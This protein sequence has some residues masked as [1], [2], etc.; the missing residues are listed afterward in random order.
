MGNKI[1]NYMGPLR[2]NVLT[3][4]EGFKGKCGCR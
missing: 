3:F 1:P 4:H 2:I